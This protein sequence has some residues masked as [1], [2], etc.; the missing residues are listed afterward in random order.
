MH[1]TCVRA[2][3]S[4]ALLAALLIAQN[5]RAEDSPP[6]QERAT[7]TS[8]FNEKWLDAVVSI[9]RVGGDGKSEAIGTGFLLQTARQHVLLMTARHVITD[10]DG[11]VI[12][13]LAFL[14]NRPAR[15]TDLILDANLKNEQLGD[16]FVS[17]T[18]DIACRFIAW[19]E[20]SK[21]TTIPQS[22]IMRADELNAGAPL[23]ILGFPLGNRSTDHAKAIL[24]SGMVAR[25]DTDGIIADVFVFPG[26]S[27]G[28][29]VYVPVIKVGGP[30]T[31]SLVNEEK[32]VGVV[33]DYIPYQEPAISVHTKRPRIVFEENSGLANLVPGEA[34]L[35]LLTRTDLEQLDVSLTAKAD[36]PVQPTPKDDTA[37]RQR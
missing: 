27:G 6:K 15:G 18:H 29:A 25:A 21:P 4:A 11:A 14:L 1:P 36:K 20:S 2:L 5:G 31:S 37:D 22:A 32:L 17:T 12:K 30:I 34:I 28:P 35:E 8:V 16:W 26:N 19:P 24:R 3:G 10:S 7:R 33:S 23:A 9:E 13:N